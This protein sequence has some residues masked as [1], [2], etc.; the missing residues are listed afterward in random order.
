MN[1]AISHRFLVLGLAFV[2][3]TAL[4]TAPVAGQETYEACYV[5]DVGAI[6]LI[7][8]TGL[9]TEC[10][11]AAHVAFSWT[12]GGAVVTDHG[13]L[14]GLAD[15]DH[16]AY[17]REGE[18]A[19]GDLGGTF[20][21]PSVAALQGNAVATTAPSDAE[22]LT[23]S[24]T[25][26][27]WEPQ[28]PPSGVT[29]H[30]LLT[31]LGDDDHGQ[32]LLVDGIRSTTNGLAVSG[33]FGTGTIPVEGGGVRMMWYP[34]KAAFRAGEA[35]TTSSWDDVNIGDHSAAFGNATTASGDFGATAVGSGTTASGDYG[36]LAGGSLTTASGVSAV[37]LGG[38]TTATGIRSTALGY[39]TTAQATGSLVLGQWNVIAGDMTSWLL[40]DPLLVAG[41][42]SGSSSRSNALTLFKNGD[43]TI[44]GTLTE[45][46]DRRLKVGIE[47]LGPVLDELDQLRPV[48]F[49][50]R[51]GTGHPG[52][53]QIGLIAQDV[54]DA[55]PEL[56][57]TGAE[58]YLSLAYPKLTAVLLRGMQEQQAE[59]EAKDAELE[60]LRARTNRLETRNEELTAR[61]DRLETVVAE[62]R[63]GRRP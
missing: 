38:G 48:R 30:G 26:G 2:V 61:L 35:G 51:E 40:T 52:E 62:L 22:V 34:A 23:W 28:T 6:Y 37:A 19:G 29:D 9:P 59:L 4:G 11:D 60:A 47:S 63:G 3:T 39:Q 18:A 14:T 20:P 13:N 10:L 32:Y 17:V 55:F 5:P 27:Q 46:S 31:G 42:G 15:D 36:S 50:F 21:T 24:A 8:Q 7:N 16:P 56:V 54:A 58:G 41:N 43:L 1:A 57:A 45:T 12:D 25:S 33:T 49:R 44:A 53:T